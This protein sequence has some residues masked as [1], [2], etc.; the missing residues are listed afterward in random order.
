MP[1]LV[2]ASGFTQQVEEFTKQLHALSEIVEV[3][4]DQGEPIR[5]VSFL[6]ELPSAYGKIM[7]FDYREEFKHIRGGWLRSRYAFELRS[8]DRETRVLHSRKAHHQHAPWDIHQHCE[9]PTAHDDHFADIERL[10]QATHE[11]F[12]K[13]FASGAPIDCAGLTPLN[14]R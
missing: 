13:Q 5:A 14:G 3:A 2:A 4:D 9:T 6:V 11:L 10:L 12:V 1:H 7:A 8:S